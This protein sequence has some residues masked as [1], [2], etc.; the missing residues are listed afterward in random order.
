MKPRALLEKFQEGTMHRARFTVGVLGMILAAGAASADVPKTIKLFGNDYDVTTNSLVGAYKNGLSVA[1]PTD[2]AD[3]ANNRRTNIDFVQG[4]DPSQDRLYVVSAPNP[5]VD[6]DSADQFFLLTGS[7]A[8]GIF[9]P[10]TSNLTQF[11]GGKVNFERGGRPT[12]VTW[13]SDENTGTK[14]DRNILL[15]TFTGDDHYRFYDLDT[16]GGTFTSDEV[17]FSQSQ[18]IKG[19]G[20]IVDVGAPGEGEDAR[21][22]GDPNAPSRGQWSASRGGPNGT[23]VAVAKPLEAEGAEVSLMDP[24][25]GKF[26]NV[27][28]NLN[29]ASGDKLTIEGT[30]SAHSLA[31][32]GGNEFWFLYTDPDPGGNGPDEVR[33]ELVRM[34]LTFPTDLNAGANSIKAN[35]LGTEPMLT[36]GLDDGGPEDGMFG[37]AFG[38]EIAPGKRIVYLTD[39]NGNILTLR[40]R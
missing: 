19:I 1:L 16:L 36:T 12:D 38:R 13:I 8:N 28:T 23:L 25:T 40:P 6:T 4:A 32:F 27:L 20:A 30:E 37:L 15:T 33:N 2:F 10:A 17:G 18:I 24:K 34:E 11:F 21:D 35:L 7:D 26:H 14:A 39:W 5:S 29:T 3:R 31:H 9:S 22:H